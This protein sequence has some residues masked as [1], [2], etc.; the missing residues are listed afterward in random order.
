MGDRVA[1]SSDTSP[2]PQASSRTLTIE[3]SKPEVVA[4]VFVAGTFTAWTPIEMQ[5]K[6]PAES[7]S[8]K[9]AALRF[10]KTFDNVS[11]G[12]QQYKFRLGNGDSWALDEKTKIGKRA[13]STWIEHLLMYI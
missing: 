9:P 4:P 7:S 6:P 10:F 8:E 1:G 2:S 13:F 5:L 3:F 12:E 11:E